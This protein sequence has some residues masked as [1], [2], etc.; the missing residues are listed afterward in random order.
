LDY[1]LECAELDLELLSDL[2]KNKYR[3]SKNKVFLLVLIGVIKILS[4]CFKSNHIYAISLFNVSEVIMVE[5]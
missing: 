5:Y 4:N 1:D 2:L 3:M